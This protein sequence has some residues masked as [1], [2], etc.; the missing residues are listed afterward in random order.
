VKKNGKRRG[1]Q[2]YKCGNCGVKFQN[3]RRTRNV[4]NGLFSEYVWN[5]QTYGNLAVR[6]GKSRQWVIN[7]LNTVHVKSN[8]R[9]SPQSLIVVADVTFFSRTNGLAVFRAPGFKKNI[10]WE[11][12]PY[13]RVDIY[14]QGKECLERNGFKITAIVLDGKRGVRALFA[15][16]PAQMCHFHQKQIVHR[17]L[18]GRPKL[19][20]GQELKTIVGT[21]SKTNEKTFT[22]QLN[23]WHVRWHEFLKERTINVETGR[24]NYTHK[25]LRSAYR[26]LKTNLP[27]LFTYQRHPELNIPNTTNSLDGFFNCLKNKLHV[28]RGMNRSHARK[29]I[30]ELLKN[31]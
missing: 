24:W 13:E 28:H 9:L 30:I 12:T 14:R 23:G 5:R 4:S 16:I 10:W 18:T 1:V 8:V 29:V 26:S 15:G 22:E 31:S 25:R 27:Y 7:M 3:R 21:L 20:A 11:F 2:T 6:Y 19:P 17:Y